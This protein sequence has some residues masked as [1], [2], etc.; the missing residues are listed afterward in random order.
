MDR[1]GGR[2][3]ASDP[4]TQLSTLDPSLVNSRR[5]R[6]AAEA[7]VHYLENRLLKLRAEEVRA[8]K[9]IERTRQKTAELLADR[10]AYEE[11][12]RARKEDARREELMRKKE[13][14]MLALKKEEQHK[15]VWDAKASLLKEK[16]AQVDAI[17]RNREMNRC[18]VQ[19]LREDVRGQARATKMLVQRQ[20]EQA[21]AAREAE[22]MQKA[23]AARKEFETR[24]Q[25]DERMRGE[26]EQKAGSMI[27]EE[28]HLIYRLKRM[29]LEKQMAV[30][31]LATAL[32]VVQVEKHED[33]LE[34]MEASE[35]AK[36]ERARGSPRSDRVPASARG[37]P[38]V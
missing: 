5:L 37:G 13:S 22:L 16:R 17:R 27:Q 26:L 10:K 21:R 4:G 18:R 9:E 20:A 24:L 1:R 7:D 2:S 25:D 12:Q 33:D 28:A 23:V 11:R 6:R 36:A 34:Q 31:D 35:R 30:K 15:G 19:I 14:A 29:H 38:A 3:A 8:L 32:R